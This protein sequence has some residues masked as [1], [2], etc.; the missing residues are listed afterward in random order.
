[1]AQST[2]EGA[3]SAERARPD[4]QR[5]LHRPDGLLARDVTGSARL[6]SSRVS[7]RASSAWSA[8]AHDVG[9]DQITAN[10]IAPG[11]IDDTEFFRG[12]MT[13]DRRQTL[14]A[15]TATG[16]GGAPADIAATALFLASP[17]AMH[18]TGQVIHVNGGALSR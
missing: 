12:R 3:G 11:F 6:S 18:I 8:L 13:D 10:V 7:S 16:R 2:A 17:G 9:A 14:I 4:E 5:R 15:Q 1:M